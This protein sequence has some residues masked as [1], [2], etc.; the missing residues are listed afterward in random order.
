MKARIHHSG[1]RGGSEVARRGDNLCGRH[2][3]HRLGPLRRPN[4]SRLRQQGYYHFS[5]ELLAYEADSAVL[6]SGADAAT[7]QLMLIR[8]AVGEKLF[9]MANNLNQ[10]TRKAHREGVR[11]NYGQC[12]HLLL[13]LETIID[14]ISL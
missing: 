7:Y 3:A 12:Q 13:S 4:S 9:S 8:K 5:K 1:R 10:L 2:V 6:S 14:H 11:L